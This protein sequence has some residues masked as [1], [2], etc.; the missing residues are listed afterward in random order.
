LM[1]ILFVCSKHV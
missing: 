1:L